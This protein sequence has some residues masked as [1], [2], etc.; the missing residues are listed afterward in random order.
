MVTER[1]AIY[2]VAETEIYSRLTHIV[3]LVLAMYHRIPITLQA[4]YVII[5]IGATLKQYS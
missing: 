5:K 1:P 3:A 4:F 2:I